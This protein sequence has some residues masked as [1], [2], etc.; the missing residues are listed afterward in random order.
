MRHERLDRRHRAPDDPSRP[1][2]V[3]RRCARLADSTQ[4]LDENPCGPRSPI[5]GGSQTGG[6]P[7]IYRVWRS[8][9]SRGQGRD[10]MSPTTL[11][12]LM[13]VTLFSQSGK[14]EPCA[15]DGQNAT[16]VCASLDLSRRV[17]NKFIRWKEAP[18]LKFGI[19]VGGA[20][21]GRRAGTRMPAGGVVASGIHGIRM[22]GEG[23]SRWRR[24]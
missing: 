5:A 3:A 23:R 16:C 22:I 18:S 24:P 15:I 1:A 8:R 4:S 14:A 6:S 13:E 2:D 9:S 21:F 17:L 10:I 7:G 20:G 12:R 19:P 11:T